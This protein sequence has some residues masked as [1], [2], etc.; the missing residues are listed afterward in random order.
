MRAPNHFFGSISLRV[1]A[2]VIVVSCLGVFSNA[3]A[4]VPQPGLGGQFEIDGNLFSNNPGGII[5]LGDD[6]LNG[7][8]GPGTGVLFNNG[9]PKDPSTTIH[10]LDNVGNADSD[11]F[12]GSNKVFANPNSYKWKSGS[13]PQ[14]DDIENGLVYFTEDNS[15]N[16]WMRLA[17][18]RGSIKG[19]SYI[20]FE[21]LQ[22]R[23]MKNAN[24]TFT[25]NGPANGRTVG[26]VLLTIHL[27]QGGS[28]A[29]F[30]AQRWQ[31]VGT[32]YDYVAINFPAGQAF[33]AA[34]I[35]S[36]VTSTYDA[37]GSHTYGINQFGEAAV[38]LDALLPNFGTCF[39]I[40]T[41]FVRTKSSTADDAVLKDFIEPYQIN[42]CLDHTPPV[43][44]PPADVTLDCTESPQPSSVG[45]ATASDDCDQDVTVTYHDTL[46][47]GGCAQNYTIERVWTATDHCGNSTQA[48]QIIRM[49]DNTP[50][51]I[52][53]SP[54]PVTVQC[55]GDIPAVNPNSI[56]ANGECGKITTTH[57]GDV[58][59]GQKCPEVITRTY[60]V[61]D[62]CGNFVDVTQK[63]TVH[64]TTPPVVE[65]LVPITVQ[66]AGDVPAP[67]IAAVKASD[68]C[69]TPTVKHISDVSNGL[70]CPE[71]ITRTYRVTD[72]CGNTTDK[73]Q[74]ITIDDTTAPIVG[75][76]YPVTVQCKGDIPAPDIAL[77]TASDNCSSPVVAFLSDVSDGKSC[78]ETITRTYRVTD[79]CGNVTDRVQQITVHDTT[80]P[81][82]QGPANV[83]VSCTGEIPS[84][85]TGLIS[86]SDNCSQ[87][88]VTWVGDQS[89]GKSCGTSILRTYRATD[90]CGNA[91]DWVQTITVDDKTAPV[92][93]PL[94]DVTVSCIGDVP[95]PSI[96]IVHATDN[97]SAVTVSHL[98]DQSDGAT[99]S[100]TIMRT[101]RVTDACG[102]TTDV[103]QKIVV[104]DKTAP[105]IVRAPRCLKV[106]CEGEVPAPD[107]TCIKATDNC[108]A[109]TVTFVS[110]ESD[111]KT[112]PATITRRYRVTDPCGNA[113]DVTQLITI[114]DDIAPVISGCGS[115]KTLE[116]PSSVVFD[117]PTA[118]DNCD[119]NP[120]VI[121]VDE[122]TTYGPEGWTYRMSKTFQ[123]FDRCGNTSQQCAQTMTIHCQAD[124]LCS[125]TQG[126][127]GNYG[128][129]FNGVPT[130]QIIRN[131]L[132]NNPLV[133]GR[134]GRS[135]TINY[136]A[137][138]CIVLRLPA[139][140]TPNTLPNIGDK[141]LNQNTC[142]ITP[143]PIPVD[144][145]GKFQNV[146]LGQTITLMLNARLSPAMPL[147]PLTNHFCTQKALPGKDGKLGTNDDV[148]DVNDPPKQFTIPTSVLTA[149]DNLGLPRI[150]WGLIQLCNIGLAAQPTGGASLSAINDAATA[151]NEGFDQCRWIVPCEDNTVAL[152][153]GGKVGDI[154]NMTI[155]NVP[156]HFELSQNAPNPFNPI[157]TIRVAIPEATDWN[158]SVFDVAGRMVKEFNGRTGGPAFVNVT[159]DGRDQHG[160]PVASGVYLYRVRADHFV[161]VKKMVLLK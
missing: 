96:G 103:V 134:P 161:D 73:T 63:I 13:V 32:G 152:T 15:G 58:S 38:N 137:A 50:P 145:N 77:V 67:N 106:E 160:S 64:D 41:V 61:S 11:V 155:G 128:G 79:A 83:T 87:P 131:L 151:I 23:L 94:A 148:P 2:P 97:C 85:D 157:T 46:I 156:T 129:T 120:S 52:V 20:D 10:I 57:L 86:A 111:G 51:N 37:F 90:A 75:L 126:F 133:L 88:T 158:V 12:D 132:S 114:D 127:Y 69:G 47:P 53:S 130:I 109:V 123:A 159:W 154:N 43:L 125:V 59:D 74:T 16:H 72:A 48:T 7:P 8:A 18:D 139:G 92:V 100:T 110:D 71:V 124:A 82:I 62:E 140:V 68:N 80:A 66:C 153:G 105:V 22:A 135:L 104:D 70:T 136:N 115:D 99:C 93:D 149:L 98:G 3:Y 54:G 4:Q 21:F 65:D 17:G 146:L 40:A 108:G 49:V 89:D 150:V 113:T 142:Q 36:A 5:G 119:P 141:T 147:F 76:L 112:C 107:I 33:V 44:T 1:F 144:S 24:G 55:D 81:T 31:P 143:T 84:P 56:V 95:A 27:T 42:L 25:S 122:K 78:P 28:Q 30:F 101:Y 91:K 118:T 14:K 45:V 102:N 34:N 138:D 26:D 60:R 19:E 35:D 121:V 116:C 29:E 117:T 39:G 9:Q 6:W